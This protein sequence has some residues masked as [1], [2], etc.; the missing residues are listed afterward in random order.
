MPVG[1]HAR[2]MN[3]HRSKWQ[4]M[5]FIAAMD[6]SGGSTGGVLERYGVEYTEENKMDLVHE[7]RL[8]MI[9]NANFNNDNIWAAIVYKDSV[10]R[11]IV[12]VLRQKSIMTYLKIDSGCTEDGTLKQ[13]P[14]KQMI[15]YAN[16]NGCIGTKMRS[17][18]KAMDILE[19]ILQQQFQLAE[20]IYNAGLMPIVEP[21]IPI[22]HPL[23]QDMEILLTAKL[24]EHLESFTGMCILKLTLPETPNQYFNISRSAKVHKLV[25]LSGG[26][27]TNE[28][29]NKLALN[30]NMTASF[31]RALSENLYYS[32]DEQMFDVAITK[33]ITNIVRA[34]NSGGA[35]AQ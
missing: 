12:D 35:L 11:G 26:Y 33:N 31:S 15:E 24:Q 29:C 2:A 17:I 23:K 20:T 25:G 19:P 6:H 8:R 18:V 32:D 4:N 13:F 21:E 9:S 10:D 14:V 28:A 30:N 7:M 3:K 1:R 27:S 5:T 16:D 22:D 34:S